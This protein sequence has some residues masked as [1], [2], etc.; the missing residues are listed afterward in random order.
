[1]SGPFG[2]S[3]WMYS[4]GFYN[5]VVNQSLRFEDGDSAKLAITPGSA[6]NRRTYTFSCWVKRST[7][8][9]DHMLFAAGA[10][11]QNRTQIYWQLQLF[12]CE[13]LCR[14]ES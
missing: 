1:M 11:A 9:A 8:S 6:S 4:S 12:W 10:N 7:I 5:N 13:V 3:Q 2:S 14:H